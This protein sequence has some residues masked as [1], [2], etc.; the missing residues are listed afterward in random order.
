MVAPLERASENETGAARISP[1]NVARVEST[2]GGRIARWIESRS[3][4]TMCDEQ[5]A[6]MTERGLLWDSD[7]GV[8]DDIAAQIE[9]CDEAIARLK[10]E[11]SR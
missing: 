6:D 10:A 7:A 11:V 3:W 5:F 1:I 9:M 2:S 8:R 4:F